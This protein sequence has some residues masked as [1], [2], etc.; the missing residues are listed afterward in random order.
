[1]PDPGAE[2]ADQV[3]QP[4]DASSTAADPVQRQA[5][6]GPA[7]EASSGTEVTAATAATPSPPWPSAS[8][9]QS[10]PSP[11]RPS[12]RN[13][14]WAPPSLRPR[15]P[16]PVYHRDGESQHRPLAAAEPE[17]EEREAGQ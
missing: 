13:A 10:G 1:V 15:Q 2:A 5:G 11:A 4:D 16:F 3:R 12:G 7:S 6:P 14:G 9:R 17:P 8:E